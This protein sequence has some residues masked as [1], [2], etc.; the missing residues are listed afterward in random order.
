VSL[1]PHEGKPEIVSAA[2]SRS[3]FYAAIELFAM[4]S[5]HSRSTA[6]ADAVMFAAEPRIS[7]LLFRA[8][9]LKLNCLLMILASKR[10]QTSAC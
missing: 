7:N 5:G 8:L 6:V 4:A 9:G 2:S 3:A 1:Q 10:T